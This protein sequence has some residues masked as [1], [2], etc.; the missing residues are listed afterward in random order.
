MLTDNLH[1]NTDIGKSQESV[2]ARPLEGG[3]TV[4]KARRVIITLELQS[5]MRVSDLKSIMRDLFSYDDGTKV[6][7]VQADVIKKEK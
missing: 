3:D 7:Q 4:M 5:D 1:G 2:P 6:I